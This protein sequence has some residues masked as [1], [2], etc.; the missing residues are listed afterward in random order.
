[1]YGINAG[2][3]VEGD[4]RYNKTFTGWTPGVGF[5]FMLGKKRRFGYDIDIN[6]P[7]RSSEYQDL[8]SLAN[9]DPNILTIS[10]PW[11]VLFSYGFHIE[12]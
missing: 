1:M 3:Y 10:K 5:E 9:N 11:P 8:I 4:N 2:M 6:V 12:F 7:I